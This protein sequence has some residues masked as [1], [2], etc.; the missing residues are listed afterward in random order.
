MD[1]WVSRKLCPFLPVGDS[2]GHYRD[3]CV[4]LS[5]VPVQRKNPADTCCFDSAHD[6]LLLAVFLL[7][8]LLLIAD[9]TVILLFS[10][11]PAVYIVGIIRN[12]I[13]LHA[14][15]AFELE[16]VKHRG[17]TDEIQCSKVRKKPSAALQGRICRQS[18][19]ISPITA[20]PSFCWNVSRRSHPDA[21]PCT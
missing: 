2:L 7:W 14:F 12:L 17:F 10:C 15:V 18:Q 9:C 21:L 11:L 5:S 19:P 16:V 3:N 13:F 1:L 4:R 20:V 6:Y 8:F